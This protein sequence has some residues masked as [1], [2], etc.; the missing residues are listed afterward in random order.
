MK[1]PK[2][3]IFDLDGVIANTVPLHYVATKQVADEVGVPFTYKMN[4]AFQGRNR[5]EMIREL[6]EGLDK[7]EEELI[8][9]GEKKNE[10]YKELIATIS[11]KD[12]LPGMIMLMKELKE[13]GVLLAIASSSSNAESV[14]NQLGVS[15]YVDYLVPHHKVTHMKPAPDIFL[16][17]ARFL[18]VNP[19][20]CVALEDSQA[21]LEAIRAARMCAIAVG[22]AV[23][24]EGAD[25]HI[26]STKSL[27]VSSI[28]QI[29]TK[30]IAKDGEIR[31]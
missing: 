5:M 19:K 25:L 12:A 31:K 26:T 7:S 15:M 22:E 6:C 27:N 30:F 16:E 13:A 4:E 1:M 3:V 8:R 10:Y 2:A 17:A 14:V 20:E 23:K 29:Y 24:E 28:L 21:G 11:E 18:K 9:L